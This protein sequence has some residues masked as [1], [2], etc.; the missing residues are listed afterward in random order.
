[1][2]K[3]IENVTCLYYIGNIAL[4][5]FSIFNFDLPEVSN[6]LSKPPLYLDEDRIIFYLYIYLSTFYGV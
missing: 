4:K 3:K 6:V 2:W 1:M 5:Y